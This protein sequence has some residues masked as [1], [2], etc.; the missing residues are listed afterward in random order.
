MVLGEVSAVLLPRQ[1]RFILSLPVVVDSSD[2]DLCL[3]HVL[4]GFDSFR[5]QDTRITQVLPDS[6][7]VLAEQGCYTRLL[8]LPIHIKHLG[9]ESG[10]SLRYLRP[11]LIVPHA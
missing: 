3:E 7:L 9:S 1:K 4:S 10:L 6:F 5:H 8:A 2:V 11:K